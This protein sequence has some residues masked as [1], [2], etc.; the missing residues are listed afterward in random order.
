M[1]RGRI[2]ALSCFLIFLITASTYW[3]RAAD[4][5]GH[6]QS[7]SSLLAPL[8]SSCCS[9]SNPA[10]DDQF[11]I[12]KKV[13]VIIET[14]PVRTLIP[15]ILHFASVLGPEWPILFFTRASV[16]STLAAFGHGSQPFKRMVQSGQIKII[17]LP[18]EPDLGKYLGL[19]NFLASEW[20]WTQM[21][22]AEYMLNFQS[23]S[24]LCANSGRKV[25]DFFDYDFVGAYHPWVS[26]AFNGGLSLRNVAMARKVVSMYNISDDVDAG[27]DD[28]LYED[29]W[30]CN[31]MKGLDAR[32][33]SEEKASE[34]A[35]D[36][37]WS[38]RPLGIHGLNRPNREQQEERKEEIF[39]WC[40]EAALAN[41]STEV[42]ELTEE[43]MNSMRI[44]EDV[45]TKGGA[46]LP[47]G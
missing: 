34:F 28:G 16:V 22:S 2:A 24:I 7:L 12:D 39:A 33:P 35:I 31:K 19:S 11:P 45:E 37:T 10:F 6:H 38:E 1:M 30:F 26:G 46:R 15:L 14:R 41:A 4:S 23:D 18:T 40:P 27:T 13:A 29:V 25:E 9:T 17:E 8:S 3:W 20:F 43:E 36:M 21:G 44:V 47:F 42:L 32:F 5:D